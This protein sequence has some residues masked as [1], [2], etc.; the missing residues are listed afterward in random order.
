MLSAMGIEFTAEEKVDLMIAVDSGMH[1]QTVPLSRIN[2]SIDHIHTPYHVPCTT[3]NKLYQYTTHPLTHFINTSIHSHT[4]SQMVMAN[5]VSM[6][7][8]Q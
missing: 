4:L 5:S 8:G 3:I 7:C 6:S 2:N 1:Q